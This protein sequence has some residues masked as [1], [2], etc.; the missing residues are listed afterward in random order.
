MKTA[1]I[2]LQALLCTPE[3]NDPQDAEVANMYLAHFQQYVSMAQ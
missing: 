2:S 3:P 1:L